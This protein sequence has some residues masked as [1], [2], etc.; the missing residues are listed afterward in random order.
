MQ[1]ILVFFC[2]EFSCKAIVKKYTCSSSEYFLFTNGNRK[3]E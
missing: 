1:T 2:L 3:I